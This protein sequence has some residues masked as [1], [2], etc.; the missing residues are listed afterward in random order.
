MRK[1]FISTLFACSAAFA[2]DIN[3]PNHLIDF[4]E[5]RSI[6]IETA[7]ERDGRRLTEA[8]FLSAMEEKDVIVLDARSANRFAERHI[9]G[10]KNLP[11]TDFTAATLESLI[12]SKDSK[13]LIYC[14]NNFLGDQRAFPS[15]SPGASLNL[16]T[17]TSLKAYGYTNVFE[18]GPLLDIHKTSISFSGS[19]VEAAQ[20]GVAPNP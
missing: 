7:A 8:Q 15:K 9:T 1:L 5:F 19:L 6:V 11:F 17:Y 2:E 12:P 13:V 10:A 20:Q 14:N 3:I 18:L 16:S 4:P